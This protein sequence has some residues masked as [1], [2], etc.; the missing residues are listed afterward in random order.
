MLGFDSISALALASF[1]EEEVILVASP[2]ILVERRPVLI[3][4]QNLFR[5][6]YG[7]T[8]GGVEIVSILERIG[9]TI[10]GTDRD[11][12]PRNNP[13][14]VKLLREIWPI[15]RGTNGTELLFYAGAQMRPEDTINWQGPM[16]FVI[17]QDVS[18]QP[19]VE[20]AYL[21]LRIESY[22]QPQWSLL[23]LELDIERTGE[24]YYT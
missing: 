24:V 3:F 9:I 6:D 10:E 23:D 16:S 1:D 17:G 18:V 5:A 12:R 2:T 20:G 11:G 19:L 7:S 13:S 22:G 21:A 15:I 4:A 8:F 14:S